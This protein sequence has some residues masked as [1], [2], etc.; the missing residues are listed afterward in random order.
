MTRL[1]RLDAFFEH[2][3]STPIAVPTGES[4]PPLTPPAGPRRGAGRRSPVPV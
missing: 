2:V 1:T 3:A 4:D